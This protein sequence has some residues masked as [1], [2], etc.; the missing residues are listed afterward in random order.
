MNIKPEKQR[1]IE[2]G[3]IFRGDLHLVERL[4]RSEH[5]RTRISQH[6][7]NNHELFCLN[8]VAKESVLGKPLN[9]NKR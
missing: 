6:S 4:N 9:T 8:L 7:E 1:T 3:M 5:S 2:A